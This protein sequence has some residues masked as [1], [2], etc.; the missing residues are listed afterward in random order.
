MPRR[1][2]RI[3]RSTVFAGGLRVPGDKSISHR[4]ALLAALADGP[5]NDCQTTLPGADCASTLACI[6]ALG[7]IG[8][9]NAVPR[10]GDPAVVTIEGRGLRAL[11]APTGDLDCGNSGSTMRLAGV[12]AAHPSAIHLDR[13]CFTPPAGR[14]KRVIEPLTRMGA[15]IEAADGSP[16][17]TIH[18]AA[19]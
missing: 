15:V 19:S 11:L 12:V 4:Y 1:R 8:L 16:P 7:A 14:C 17:L 10:T 13:R 9:T 18:G 3:P 6:S 2:T 5:F